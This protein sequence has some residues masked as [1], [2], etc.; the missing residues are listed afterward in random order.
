VGKIAN[1]S[2]SDRSSD[3]RK[4]RQRKQKQISVRQEIDMSDEKKIP[5]SL[6]SGLRARPSS[7]DPKPAVTN[8]PTTMVASPETNLVVVPE[9]SMTIVPEPSA[10]ELDAII[11]API[12]PTCGGCGEPQTQKGNGWRCEKC[13]SIAMERMVGTST[14]AAQAAANAEPIPAVPAVDSPSTLAHREILGAAR[15]LQLACEAA[16]KIDST[17][18]FA[19]SAVDHA[20]IVVHE[21]A[22]WHDWSRVDDEVPEKYRMSAMHGQVNPQNS[23]IAYEENSSTAIWS[24]R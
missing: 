8:A 3:V 20:K 10:R 9:A 17:D 13:Y 4:F 16:L 15:Q 21:I 22:T 2:P 1:I 19:K 6:L 5:S 23:V 11:S 18:V 12:A 14:V 24:R 7:R